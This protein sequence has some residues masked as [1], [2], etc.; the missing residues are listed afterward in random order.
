LSDSITLPYSGVHTTGT[1]F[2]GEVT[3]TVSWTP[4]ENHCDLSAVINSTLGPSPLTS[5]YNAVGTPLSDKPYY[6][7]FGGESNVSAN[8][9]I[10]LEVRS[11]WGVELLEDV[12]IWPYM[13]GQYIIPDR[14]TPTTSLII[15]FQL[16]IAFTLGIYF[17]TIF[18]PRA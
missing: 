15:N 17:S 7:S 2:A 11:P 10:T 6:T 12:I 18:F 1:E 4:D 16:L 13:G 3:F 14:D 5:F 9:P 8:F